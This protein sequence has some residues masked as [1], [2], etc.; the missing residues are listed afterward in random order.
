MNV[1]LTHREVE[2]LSLV[3]TGLFSCEVAGKLSVSKRTVDFHLANAYRKLGVKSR[4]AA[5]NAARQLGLLK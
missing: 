4:I 2:I 3:A 5:V 1:K